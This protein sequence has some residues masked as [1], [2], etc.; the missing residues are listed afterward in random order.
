MSNF[1]R[2]ISFGASITYGSELPD[3]SNT[4][5]SIIAK[6]L[7]ASYLCLAKPAAANASIAREILSFD[8]YSNDVVLVMWTSATRYEFRTA[9]GWEN[10]S[11][12]SDQKGFV[13]EWYRGP[14]DYEYTEVATTLRDILLAKQFLDSIEIPYLFVFD[15]NEL[16]T[17]YTW[18]HCDSY[19]AAMANM[20]PWENMLWFNDTGFLE[21]CRDNNYPFINTHPG[22]EAH[23]AAA[24]YI[25]A[26][27]FL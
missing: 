13:K 14:G 21:W 4:W 7:T 3:P 15:N 17:S 22:T 11:P 25:L 27:S 26:N 16:R 24:D 23:A 18:E 2:V 8:S 12:W 5:S 10:I 6:K 19:I 20:L 9:N 1:S